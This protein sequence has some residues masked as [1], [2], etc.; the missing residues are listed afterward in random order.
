MANPMAG[1]AK[2]LPALATIRASIGADALA[3]VVVFLVAPPLC[4][5][6]AVAS[7][8]PPTAGL[9]TGIIGGIVVSALAVALGQGERD[10]G[11]CREPAGGRPCPSRRP[12]RT[13]GR[14]GGSR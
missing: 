11:A 6:A 7:G 4:M 8:L 2:L 5:G 13:G 12:R 10:R 14:E 3:S 1:E 9:I